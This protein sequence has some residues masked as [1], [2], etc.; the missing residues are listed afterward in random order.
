MYFLVLTSNVHTCYMDKSMQTICVDLGQSLREGGDDMSNNNITQNRNVSR[1]F[2]PNYINL[3][4]TV[5]TIARFI[6]KL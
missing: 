5:L 6:S 1:T 4:K 2:Y 3:W